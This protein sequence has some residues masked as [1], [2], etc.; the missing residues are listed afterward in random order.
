MLQTA[1]ATHPPVRPGDCVFV[2]LDTPDAARAQRLVEALRGEVG[3]IKIGNELFTAQ[4][5]EGVRA[6]AGGERLFLDLKF[7]DIPNTVAGAVRSATRLR[8]FCLTLH[9]AGGRAM[10]EAAA[11]AA[12]A[13]VV[14][15]AS[16]PCSQNPPCGAPHYRRWCRPVCCRGRGPHNQQSICGYSGPRRNAGLCTIC[17]DR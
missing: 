17:R 7:H 3:G 8:P 2:A 14:K 11:R 5:P 4:G 6:V 16:I 10:M 12:R 15:F 9:V 1:T 13:S